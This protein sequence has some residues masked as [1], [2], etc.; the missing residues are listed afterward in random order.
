[1][2][3]FFALGIESGR[4]VVAVTVVIQ[5]TVRIVRKLKMLMLTNQEQNAL[6]PMPME[7][8]TMK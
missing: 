4:E 6:S 2:I 8:Q 3:F 1:M 7:K 5:K